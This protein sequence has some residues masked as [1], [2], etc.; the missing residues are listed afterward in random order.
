MRRELGASDDGMILDFGGVSAAWRANLEPLLDHS[1][2]G[3][4]NDVLPGHFQPPTAELL[5]EFIFVE[6]NAHLDG[7]V[8]EVTV[9]ET[10]TSSAT[11]TAD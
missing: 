11:A 8:K 9:W 10:E 2:L 4:L 7:M 1:G 5:A 3:T 6:M